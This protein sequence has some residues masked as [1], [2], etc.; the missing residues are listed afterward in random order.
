MWRII[1]VVLVVAFAAYRVIGGP[2][3][4]PTAP[5][6]GPDAYDGYIE[7][8]MLMQGGQRE[9]ELV[10]IEER[11]N[12]ADCEA[13]D[14]N[15]RVA[16]LCPA[17]KGLS[18]TLKSLECSREIEPRF[19]KMLDKKPVSVHY[20][21]LTLDDTPDNPRRSIVLGWGMTEQESQLVCASIQASA[22]KR[23]LQGTVTCI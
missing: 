12:A 9:I 8:R 1:L 15:A 21:H 7:V 23:K 20:A 5:S 19:Q 10:A 3:G 18:C 2:G 11:P 13:K 4:K 14:G 22:S 17:S 16:R 6:A